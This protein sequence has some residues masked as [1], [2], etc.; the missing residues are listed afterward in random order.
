V[1]GPDA[2]PPTSD[3]PDAVAETGPNP[4]TLRSVRRRLLEGSAWVFGARATSLVM[5]VVIASFLGRLLTTEEL[6]VYASS[7]TLALFGSAIAKLGL[8][9]AV[10]RFAAGALGTGETGRARAAIRVAVGLGSLAAIALGIVMAIGPGQALARGLFDSPA[11]AAAIPLAAGWL[12]ATAI[13]SLTV[14]SFR[15]LSAFNF[16]TIF[17]ALVVDSVSA[18]AFA[19]VWV[20]GIDVGAP[21]VIAISAGVTALVAG[22]GTT[23][24]FRRTRALTGPGTVAPREMLHVGWPLMITNIAILLLGSGV[25][26]LILGAFQPQSEVGLYAAA[27]RLVVFVVTPFVVFSGVIPPIIAE[28]HAQGKMRQLERA[29]RAGATLAGIPSFAILLVFLLFGPW[30][31]ETV[32]SRPIYREAAPILVVLSLGRL[33]AVWAGSAGVTLMMTGHQ[34]AMMTTTL[35]CGVFSVG[36]GIAGA[37][38]AGAIGVAIATS[39]AQVLQN[40]LQLAI[41]HRRLGVWTMIH[42]SPRELYRYLRPHGRRGEAAEDAAEQVAEVLVQGPDDEAPPSRRDDAP[43]TPPETPPADDD[44]VSP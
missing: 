2:A 13:Q 29:L 39:T 40:T 26:L 30:V 23:L 42:L 24:L 5:G 14:E 9:R 12:V 37:Y 25:D 6:G 19:A 36:A 34:R 16:A 10:V 33:V 27:S 43:Q 31:L 38:V 15:G 3:P 11:L 7:F 21:G 44:D 20:A 4:F 35:A 17:D 18:A 32:W 22:L 8:D 41:V 1:S 28:L